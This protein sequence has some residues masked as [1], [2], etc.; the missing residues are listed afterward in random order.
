MFVKLPNILAILQDLDTMSIGRS[1]VDFLFLNRCV[2]AD[3]A[4]AYDSPA[5]RLAACAGGR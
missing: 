5:M 4:G 1:S 2:F 3:A